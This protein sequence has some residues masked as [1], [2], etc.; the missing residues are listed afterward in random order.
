M[1]RCL[2]CPFPSSLSPP[3]PL[4]T[5]MPSTAKLQV[6][7]TEMYFCKV[8][9]KVEK[10]P[11]WGERRWRGSLALPAAAGSSEGEIGA[12]GGHRGGAE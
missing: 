8:L 6:P 1:T 7:G 9:P 11:W 12:L 3:A 5:S 2:P 10:Q 4:S